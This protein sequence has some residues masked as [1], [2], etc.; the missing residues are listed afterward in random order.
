MQLHIILAKLIKVGMLL[1]FKYIE[2]FIKLKNK[3]V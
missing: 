3:T 2:I 1:F